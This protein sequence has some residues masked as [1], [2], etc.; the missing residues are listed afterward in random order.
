[1]EIIENDEIS[2]QDLFTSNDKKSISDEEIESLNVIIQNN[3]CGDSFFQ[4]VCDTLE[5]DHIPFKKVSGPLG[6]DIDNST[7][8]TLDMQYSAGAGTLIFAPVDN[9]RAGYSD[10]LALAMKAGLMENGLEHLYIVSGMT[11]FREDEFG[12]VSQFVPTPTE[13]QVGDHFNTNFVTLSFGTYNVD[14]KKVAKGIES[15]LA[16]H[17]SYLNHYDAGADLIYK[18]RSGED[19]NVVADYFSTSVRD[20]CSY[21]RI[22][23]MDALEERAIVN[24]NVQQMDVFQSTVPFQ[25]EKAN[26]KTY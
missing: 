6:E 16:R 8:V 7:I 24:P 5:E 26:Q 9:T 10:S 11:G 17:K 22:K 20:L 21:N 4:K 3:D 25:I 13:E 23:A 18:S 14:P 12:N 2:V 1:M 19:V 15:G